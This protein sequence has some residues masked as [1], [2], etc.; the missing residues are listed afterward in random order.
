LKIGCVNCGAEIGLERDEPFFV[1]PFC[2][3]SLFLDRA[4]TFKDLLFLPLLPAAAARSKLQEELARREIP[5]CPLGA[6]EALLVPFWGVRGEELQETVPA[7][8][9]VPA[10]LQ[11]YRLP[12]AESVFFTPDAA[13]GFEPMPCAEAASAAW[14]GRKD[15]SSFSLYRVPFFKVSFSAG[16][17]SYEGWVDAVS[18]RVLLDQTPPPVSGAISSRYLTLVFALFGVFTLAA[19]IVPGFGWSLIVVGAL[20]A[21]AVPLVKRFAA[22]GDA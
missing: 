3:S 20:A 9:P 16:T 11:G 22:G 4:K 19:A 15:V 12:S 1:C 6:V 14:Q 2:N 18:G 13:E 5:P 8:S 21:A 17:F 10:G 7:F